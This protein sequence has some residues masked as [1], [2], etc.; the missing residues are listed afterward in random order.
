MQDA[1][2]PRILALQTAVPGHVLDQRTVME[3][4]IGLFRDAYPDLDRLLPIYL[5]AAIGTRYSC[6]PLSWYLEPHGLKERSRLFVEHSLA[7]MSE[8]TAGCLSQLD[9]DLEEI[10]ALV[11]VSTSGIAT[12]SLDALLIE[13]LK[14]P[15]G[16]TRLPIF[17]LGCAGGVIGL[18]RA[19]QIARAMPGKRV[20]FLVVELCGLTFRAHDMSKSNLVATALFGDGA[21]AALISTEGEGPRIAASGEHTFPGTLDVMGWRIEDDGFGVL[22]SRDIPA[23]IRASFRPALDG[24]L[25]DSA[26]AFDAIEEFLCHPGGAKVIEAL[27]QVLDQRPGSFDLARQVLRR[28]GNMSA[29]TVMFVLDAARRGPGGDR[30]RRLLSSLGPGFT[31]AFLALEPA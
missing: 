14:L 31:A 28:Y 6:V 23:I 19:G 8:A 27:E 29:A 21:A 13:H 30:P 17:G 9:L 11:V 24:F 2:S 15:R 1:A 3:N 4:A 16:I 10:D 18:A 7:L 20:L 12:P 26:L 22:F 25:A 5:N